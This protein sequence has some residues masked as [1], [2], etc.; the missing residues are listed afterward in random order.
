VL[1]LLPFVALILVYSV[2]FV[3]SSFRLGEV[4]QAPGGLPLRWVVKALLPLGFLL[5]LVAVISRLTRVWKLLFGRVE[6]D[7]GR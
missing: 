7:H 5:L 3:I 4:S 1:F 6:A 2:P